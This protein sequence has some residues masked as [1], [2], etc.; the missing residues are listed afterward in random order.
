MPGCSTPPP[1]THPVR[2]R[3]AVLSAGAR[4]CSA[5]AAALAEALLLHLDLAGLPAF[6]E[7]AAPEEP[8]LSEGYSSPP[9]DRP[10]SPMA[11]PTP[12]GGGGGRS[13]ALHCGPWGAAAQVLGCLAWRAASELAA[14]P[15]AAM[16]GAARGSQVPPRAEV[17]AASAAAVPGLDGALEVWRLRVAP[18]V[19]ARRGWWPEAMGEIQALPSVL[20]P[21]QDAALG[22]PPTATA[23]AAAAGG[24]GGGGALGPAA[25]RLVCKALVVAFVCGADSGYATLAANLLQRQAERQQA[26]EREEQGGEEHMGGGERQPAPMDVDGHNRQESERPR[27]RP[28]LG[29]E[30]QPLLALLGDGGVDGC[31]S[32]GGGGGTDAGAWVA[33][34]CAAALRQALNLSGSLAAH[35]LLQQVHQQKR[36]LG[37]P[38]AEFGAMLDMPLAWW[39]TFPQKRRRLLSQEQQPGPAT[40][41]AVS[42]PGGGGAPGRPQQQAGGLLARLLLEER[43]GSGGGAS[44]PAGGTPGDRAARGGIDNATSSESSS[45][46]TEGAQMLS[47]GDSDDESFSDPSR[48]EEDEEEEGHEGG[49]DSPG[50]DFSLSSGED[51]EDK[52]RASVGRR[53]GGRSGSGSPLDGGSGG[54]SGSTSLSGSGASGSE[55]EMELSSGGGDEDAPIGCSGSGDGADPSR[56]SSGRTADGEHHSPRRR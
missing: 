42:H 13:A 36:L 35:C 41:T 40:T 34:T 17:P 26:M 5:C 56:G 1:A 7:A 2:P 37:Q 14:A 9:G 22:D 48:G 11:R 8:A 45:G 3:T 29:P 32:S 43:G 53:G 39:A 18:A 25:R 52:E 51:E 44:G 15:P 24:S 46:A 31:G 21:E 10:A 12:S 30:D 23:A 20:A 55:G 6:E 49:S 38:S 27:R 33:R 19:D 16:V 28:G 54:D 50:S 47:L 4:H